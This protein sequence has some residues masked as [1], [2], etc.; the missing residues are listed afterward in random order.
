MYDLQCLVA[1]LAEGG[2]QYLMTLHQCGEAT[3][4]GFGVEFTMQTQ[5]RRNVVGRAAR[6][7]LPEKPLPLLGVGQLQRLL[8]RALEYR[9]YSIQVHSLTLEQGRQGLAFFL[10]E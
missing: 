3:F 6:F 8:R 2:A 4:Q 10:R 7:Q 1:F 9:G 5:D